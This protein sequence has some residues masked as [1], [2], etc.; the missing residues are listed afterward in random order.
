VLPPKDRAKRTGAHR[1]G[2]GE[3]SDWW[4]VKCSLHNVIGKMILMKRP[5]ADSA[6]VKVLETD[7]LTDIALIRSTLDNKRIKYF[8]QGE[9]MKHIRNLDPAMLMVA[10]EDIEIAIKLLKPLKLNYTR[11]IFG[12]NDK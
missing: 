6:F 8:I 2:G 5:I 9:N 4:D 11:I 3:C 7:S 1:I 12:T 10:K